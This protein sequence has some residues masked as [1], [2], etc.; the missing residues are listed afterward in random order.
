MPFSSLFDWPIVHLFNLFYFF[1]IHSLTLSWKSRTVLDLQVCADGWTLLLTC[2]TSAAAVDRE[3][4]GGGGGGRL[5]TLYHAR[6]GRSVSFA[7]AG[8]CFRFGVAQVLIVHEGASISDKDAS[9]SVTAVDLSDIVKYWEAEGIAAVA[10]GVNNP[11][12]V[13][14]KEPLLPTSLPATLHAQWHQPLV[15]VDKHAPVLAPAFTGENGTQVDCVAA[16]CLDQTSDPQLPALQVVSRTEGAVIDV[17]LKAFSKAL[18]SPGGVPQ[19]SAPS[20]ASESSSY[21]PNSPCALS[22][23]LP[24]CSVHVWSIGKLVYVLTERGVLHQCGVG[25]A[26]PQYVGAAQVPLPS[27]KSVPKV[28]V[29]PPILKQK[30]EEVFAPTVVSGPT[31]TATFASITTSPAPVAAVAPVS[32]TSPP[33]SAASKGAAA[34]SVSVSP[35]PVVRNWTDN[36]GFGLK[37]SPKAR[38]PASSPVSLPVDASAA[39]NNVSTEMAKAVG[40]EIEGMIVGASDSEQECT[41]LAENETSPA[42]VIEHAEEKEVQQTETT[43]LLGSIAA[44]DGHS[45]TQ[46]ATDFTVS[47]QEDEVHGDAVH[48]AEGEACGDSNTSE[49]SAV[50]SFVNTD[51]KES[52]PTPAGAAVEA[53][54]V[55]AEMELSNCAPDAQEA[56]S[57]VAEE[58]VSEE[59]RE[60][61]PADGNASDVSSVVSL[62]MESSSDKEA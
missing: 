42:A 4:A 61:E 55:D 32:E 15:S 40:N 20:L 33:R 27:V 46:P 30:E 26:V 6:S 31:T 41:T 2:D 35:K 47:P 24:R 9:L 12:L 59:L 49:T 3:V 58:K 1:N 45:S 53:P 21:K 25:A 43:V 8:G 7:A 50:A 37:K 5:L 17:S 56:R 36:P 10:P 11:A 51:T 60:T 23:A 54:I 28:D 13:H 38:S 44:E 48:N 16:A 62:E 14:Y 18:S 22:N 57:V 34:V 29:L 52:F 19:Q 39:N